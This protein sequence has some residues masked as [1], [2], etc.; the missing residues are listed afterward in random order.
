[1]WIITNNWKR[2][3]FASQVKCPF[4]NDGNSNPP[5]LSL[6]S[7]K[8]LYYIK[9]QIVGKECLVSEY[10]HPLNILLKY[11]PSD[12]WRVLETLGVKICYQL[13]MFNIVRETSNAKYVVQNL[14]LRNDNVA[15]I[16][17][18]VHRI[19]GFTQFEDK[20][21]LVAFWLHCA[22]KIKMTKVM[23]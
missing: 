21:L 11:H 10:I 2:F 8:S 9:I 4:R 22:V 12:Q 18:I 13:Q 5:M 6:N 1:M 7:K 19:N 3:A 15:S 20:T 23:W 17:S 16:N 14:Q